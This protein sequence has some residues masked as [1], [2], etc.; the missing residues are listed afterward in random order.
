MEILLTYDMIL[1]SGV[2][3]NDPLSV[4]IME[5]SPQCLVNVLHHAERPLFFSYDESFS[6]LLPWQLSKYHSDC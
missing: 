2:Q 4:S 3:H 6:D 5:R 1:V